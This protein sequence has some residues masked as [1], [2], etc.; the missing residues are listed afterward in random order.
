M[1]IVGEQEEKNGTISVRK[2]GGDDLGSM[3]VSAFAKAIQEEIDA[4]MKKF[5][6]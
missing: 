4:T 6:V 2:H 5:E 3:D 1:I